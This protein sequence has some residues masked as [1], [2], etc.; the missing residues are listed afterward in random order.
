M[1]GTAD[2][3]ATVK[4]GRDEDDLES[5]WDENIAVAEEAVDQAWEEEMLTNST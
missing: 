3:A 1:S 5:N 2:F 4:F